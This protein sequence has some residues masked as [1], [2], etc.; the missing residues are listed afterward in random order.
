MRSPLKD[1]VS[2]S[3]NHSTSWATLVSVTAH[4]ESKCC[5]LV[6][7]N[8]PRDTS[9]YDV[10]GGVT[11]YFRGCNKQGKLT[12]NTKASY[13]LLERKKPGWRYQQYTCLLAKCLRCPKWGHNAISICHFLQGGKCT[14]AYCLYIRA[15]M[16]TDHNNSNSISLNIHGSDPARIT[17]GIAERAEINPGTWNMCFLFVAEVNTALIR[18]PF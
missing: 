1:R 18:W 4:P 9:L 11:L 16:S 2:R 14:R 15:E 13:V 5:L 8:L 6:C 7:I 12:S 17:S 3:L 10:I